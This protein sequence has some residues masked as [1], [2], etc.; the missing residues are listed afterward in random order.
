MTRARLLGR[1]AV[2][3]AG[4]CTTAAAAVAWRSRYR[5]PYEP[6]VERIELPLPPGHEGLAGFRIGFVTDCHVGP[7]FSAAA[8]ARNLEPLASEEVDVCLFGGDYVSESARFA[9]A[10]A[11]VLKDLAP[12]ARH[13]GLAV[14]GNHDCAVGHRKV[15]GALEAAG[16]RVLRN[17]A[18][19]IE[20]AGGTLWI[21]GIDDALL[22]KP[23]PAA[24][25][26]GL[27]IGAAALGLWHE[28][29][30]AE[31]TAR[32]GAF[33]QLSG[34]THGG[35]LCFPLVGPLVL[36]PG[37]RRFV[38]GRHEA[39]GMPVYTSRGIGVYRPPARLRC[40]PELTV[41]T[42]TSELRR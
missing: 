13:G 32:L 17:Q 33:A 37:G 27:P 3:A 39:S 40:P 24:A 29:D 8:L 42:L 5:A 34:H 28:P 16:I 1:A 41:A 26:A 18:V 31:Q 2:G 14:L 21:V 23:D 9:P 19:P 10:A 20:T 22:G 15:A 4:L 36:P 6:V 12:R 25:F 11:I 35:Q 30:F 38:G 7:T